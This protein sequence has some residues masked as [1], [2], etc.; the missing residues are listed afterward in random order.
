[1]HCFICVDC[2]G[3]A[4]AFAAHALRK[5]DPV[6]RDFAVSISDGH[7]K[8]GSRLLHSTKGTLNENLCS[9]PGAAGGGYKSDAQEFRLHTSHRAC[10]ACSERSG[11]DLLIL[12]IN[13][14][15]RALQ[16]D[17]HRA[18]CRSENRLPADSRA[19]IGYARKAWQRKLRS[20][21]GA[22][23]KRFIVKAKANIARRKRK[24]RSRILI[25][26]HGVSLLRAV[27]CVGA[28]DT[29]ARLESRSWFAYRQKQKCLREF[30]RQQEV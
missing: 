20:R 16:N 22:T 26:G 15:H 29:R 14:G 5:D 30:R 13:V 21:G 19:A 9:K 7:R 6:H 10:F 4:A 24:W 27:C 11:V 3:L 25:D 12:R 18:G 28:R 1:M 17:A 8:S 23:R 2:G